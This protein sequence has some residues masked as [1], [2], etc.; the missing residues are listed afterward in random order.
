M[1]KPPLR[2]CDTAHMRAIW[3][4]AA[5]AMCAAAAWAQQPGG[6]QV[7]N[8]WARATPGRSTESVA[9][10]KITNTGTTPDRLIGASTPIAA[11]ASLHESKVEKGIMKMRALDAVPLAA[12]QTVEFKPNG[13]HVMLTGLKQP[14]KQGDSF[15]LTLKFEKAGEVAINVKVERAGAMSMSGAGM[16]HGNMPMDHGQMGH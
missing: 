6:V 15:P 1:L 10:L 2:L 3:F 13:D 12:G 8:A 7:D 4:V 16:N 14:L 5:F 9:Y 11:A